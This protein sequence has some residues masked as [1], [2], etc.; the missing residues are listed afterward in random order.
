MLALTRSLIVL[1]A[2]QT[3]NYLEAASTKLVPMH[4]SQHHPI[5]RALSDIPCKPVVSGTSIM[6]HW[7]PSKSFCRDCRPIISYL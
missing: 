7:Y 1:D 4:G 5:R 2:R 3:F 6:N